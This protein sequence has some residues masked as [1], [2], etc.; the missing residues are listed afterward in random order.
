MGVI[1]PIGLNVDEVMATLASG[2][3]GIRLWE[4]PMLAKKFPAGIVPQDFSPDFPRL[5]LPYLDRCSQMAIIAAQQA[6]AD[7]GMQDFAD[8]GQRAALFYGSVRGGAQKEEDWYEQL[9]VQQKQA[10]RPFALFAIMLNAAAAQIS[11]R[12][13]ILGPVITNNTACSSSGTAIGCAYRSILDGSLDIAIAGGA[14]APLTNS[15]FG[16]WDGVRALAPPDAVDIGRSCKPFSSQRTGLVISEGAAFVVLESLEHAKRRGAS[17][18]AALTGYGTASDGY[19]IGSPKAEGEAAA[20]R[21]ALDDAGLAPRDIQYLNA[22]ATATRGGDTVEAEAIRL[23]FGKAI[24]AVPVSSTKA[25]HGHLLGATS[26]LEFIISVGALTESFLPATAYLDDIDPECELN[27]VANEAI[28]DHPVD[29]A[30]S[31]SSGLGGTNVALI[32]AKQHELPTKRCV[33][34]SSKNSN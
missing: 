5:E 7:A 1:S 24:D 6:I 34:E 12:H 20:M 18:Y 30:M 22:H 27:H 32:V 26:A 8:Y 14:E 21:A 9:L 29:T 23:A 13:Q 31:F 19:H 11:I 28:F 33:T 17:C 15:M 3:S 16:V 25:V 4:S 10:S 2:R